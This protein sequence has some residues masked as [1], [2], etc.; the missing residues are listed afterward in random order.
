MKVYLSLSAKGDSGSHYCASTG[1][2]G[3]RP[4]WW[5]QALLT[6]F[7]VFFVIRAVLDG[8]LASHAIENDSKTFFTSVKMRRWHMIV[9]VL[10]LSLS[11]V[12]WRKVR[13]GWRAGDLWNAKC[14]TALASIEVLAA[15]TSTRF[16]PPILLLTFSTLSL[17]DS[18]EKHLMHAETSWI[19]ECLLSSIT[20]LPK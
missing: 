8:V 18:K 6:K 2:F 9:W 17:G 4:Y 1:R 3:F 20:F 19:S 12:Q 16:Q 5:L 15:N 13:L 7:Y 14:Q 10:D 11:C